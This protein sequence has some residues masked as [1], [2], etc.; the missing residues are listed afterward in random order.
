MDVALTTPVAE[1]D[2]PKVGGPSGQV[3]GGAGGLRARSFAKPNKE[4]PRNREMNKKRG[5]TD[6]WPL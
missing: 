6:V 4:L 2:P 1:G 3:P 5:P